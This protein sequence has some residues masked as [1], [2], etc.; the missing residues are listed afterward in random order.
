LTNESEDLGDRVPARI[1]ANFYNLNVFAADGD[2][3]ENDGEDE[4]G[5]SVDP[6]KL[7][8]SVPWS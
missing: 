1:L 3:G 4:G 6:S 8:A 7:L 2:D 5:V